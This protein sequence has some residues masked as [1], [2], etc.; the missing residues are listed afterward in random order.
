MSNE[1]PLKELDS[2]YWCKHCVDYTDQVLNR[3]RMVYRCRT[4]KKTNRDM[5]LDTAGGRCG[6]RF[7]GPRNPGKTKKAIDKRKVAC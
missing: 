5:T 4:C 6:L 1:V 2:Y 7:N 3:T